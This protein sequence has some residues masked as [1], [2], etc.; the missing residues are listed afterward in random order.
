MKDAKQYN[1]SFKF[2]D[3]ASFVYFKGKNNNAKKTA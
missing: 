1:N 3:F 2:Y